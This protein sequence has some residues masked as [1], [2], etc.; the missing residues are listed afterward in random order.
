MHSIHHL[1]I[2]DGEADIKEEVVWFVKGEVDEEV[3]VNEDEGSQEA[4]EIK[5]EGDPLEPENGTAFLL[6]G[7]LLIFV[8][9]VHVFTTIHIFS[10][11]V[12]TLKLEKYF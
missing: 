1:A 8:E 11:F 7:K 2:K 5:M 10:M 4:C 3:E 9:I 12:S 6:L